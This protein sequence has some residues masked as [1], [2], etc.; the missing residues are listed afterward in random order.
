MWWSWRVSR[1]LFCMLNFRKREIEGRA[2]IEGA[3][4][5]PDV[6]GNPLVIDLFERLL[7]PD[8]VCSYFASDTPMPGSEYQP[9]HRDGKELFP[10]VPVTVVPG[11]T[12]APA[13]TSEP[14]PTTTPS[15][16][17]EPI[18]IKQKSSTVHA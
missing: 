2:L 6:I 5:A 14:L 15:S 16:R 4:A 12:S 11:V 10:G 17:I 8:L 9:V 1:P 18:P 7:G 13:P 3:F